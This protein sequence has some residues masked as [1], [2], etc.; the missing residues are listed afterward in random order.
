MSA[1]QNFMANPLSSKLKKHGLTPDTK[2]NSDSH[3]DSKEESSQ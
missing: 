1:D 2:Y 3:S